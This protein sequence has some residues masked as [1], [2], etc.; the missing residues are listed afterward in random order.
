MIFYFYFFY[1]FKSYPYLPLP[2]LKEADKIN[3]TSQNHIFKPQ[4]SFNFFFFK[5]RK[6]LIFKKIVI[7]KG[8]TTDMR[9]FTTSWE[10]PVMCVQRGLLTCY[11]PTSD[12]PS[13]VILSELEV[14]WSIWFNFNNGEFLKK[15]KSFGCNITFNYCFYIYEAQSKNLSL[16]N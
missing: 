3:G 12:S 15:K 14:F 13:L 8:K 11:T 10:A 5:S 4:S 1:T 7:H 2:I 16:D 9:H 6:W